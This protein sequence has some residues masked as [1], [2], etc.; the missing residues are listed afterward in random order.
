V[1]VLTADFDSISQNFMLYSPSGFEGWYF[2]PWD[3][4]GAWGWSEQPG[5]PS[6]P[7]SREGLANWWGVILHQRFLADPGNLA[8]LDRRIAELTS[9]INDASTAA[10]LARFHD[11]VAAFISAPPDLGN[12]PCDYAGTPDAVWQWEAEYRRV[13]G[14]VSRARDEYRNFADRPMPFWLDKPTIPSPGRVL[15][16]WRPSFQLHGQPITYDVEVNAS[17]QFDRGGLVVR[18]TDLDGATFSTDA[19]PSGHYFWRVVARAAAHPNED[20]QTSFDDHLF[21]DVP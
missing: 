6:R 18:A 3:Y 14:N 9:T 12:L 21:V 2:L 13:A 17:E 15:F 10:T 7:R 11:L 1:N 16:S 8:Q 5:A 4:D 20:W 19:L